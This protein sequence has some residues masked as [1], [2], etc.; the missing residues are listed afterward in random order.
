MTEMEDRRRGFEQK[1][2]FD[3]ELRFK[4][5]ARRNRLFGLWAAEQLGKSGADA[6]AYAKEVVIA[7]LA[8]AGDK[9][10]IRKVLADFQAAG[11]VSDE[12]QLNVRLVDL[13]AKAIE[14]VDKS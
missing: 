5:T 4:A 8:E 13:M 9:D 11:V 6:E 2:A 7:D 3:E 10:V 12:G 14:Q 1:F